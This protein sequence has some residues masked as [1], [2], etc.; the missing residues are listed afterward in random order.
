MAHRRDGRRSVVP[1]ATYLG[2]GLELSA[3]RIPRHVYS[4]EQRAWVEAKIAER[5]DLTD[6]EVAR[7][8]AKAH[9]IGIPPTTVRRWRNLGIS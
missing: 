8:F 2:R 7:L 4:D 1:T 5:P 6:T 9:D 3:R